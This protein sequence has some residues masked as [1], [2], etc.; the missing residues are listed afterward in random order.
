MESVL[1]HRIVIG[2]AVL[3]VAVVSLVVGIGRGGPAVSRAATSPGTADTVSV[4][5]VGT[6]DGAP[7]TLTVS[8]TVHATR[9][10]VQTALDAQAADARRVLAALSRSGV[11]NKR[12]Q[13]TDLSLDRH[14]DDHGTPTGY[15]ASETLQ[16]RI[17]PLSRAGTTIAAAAHSAGN[18]VSIG[19][20]SFDVANDD[21]LL[22][23]A[24]SNAF[25]D[26]KQKAQ[27]YADLAGRSLGTVQKI[28]ETV[29]APQPVDYYGASL[30]AQRASAS[31]ATPIRAGQQTL[32]VR[33][34]VVWTLS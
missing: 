19:G 14:Y 15:D 6:A 8:F 22:S 10:T 34:T 29:D 27:Q 16:A 20:M 12:I 32:T 31:A 13:T 33:V 26:A 11:A 30:D 25:A 18:D 23:S 28:S 2:A 3:A 1:R 17:T 5:G 24:R 21:S 9:L 4:T 7:D